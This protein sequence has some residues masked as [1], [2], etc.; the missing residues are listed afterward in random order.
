MQDRP[1]GLLIILFGVL[2]ISP[3]AVLVRYL[4][5]GGAEPWTIIFWKMLFAIPIT[6]VFAVWE[7]GSFSQLWSSM[8]YSK[9]YYLIAIPLQC[10]V[11]IFF[12]LSFV[13]TSAA[14]ALLLIN[15]NPLWCAV[16]GRLLLGDQ[17][18]KKTYLALVLALGCMLIIFI[19]EL[20]PTKS[21]STTMSTNTTTT[22]SDDTVLLE[23]AHLFESSMKGN[24]IALCTGLGLAAYIT[25]VRHGSLK[26]GS[27]INTRHH[28]EE[29]EE[30]EGPT[31]QGPHGQQQLQPQK[32]NLVGAAAISATV[33]MLLSVL[34]RQG[35]VLPSTFWTGTTLWSF[36]IAQIAEGCAIGI[37][38]IVMTI[39]PRYI[40]G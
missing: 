24:I 35:D 13:Y 26:G 21:S 4:S 7:A 33:T 19:P 34:V 23:P 1:K 28:H 22:I 16:A 36:W 3:D 14:L 11:D 9:K 17:L 30:G 18:K 8:V 39:A 20:L 40:T 32:I 37:I 6:A 25:I 2:I 29:E 5:E 12:T 38:F 31:S 27:T 15:I 10:V